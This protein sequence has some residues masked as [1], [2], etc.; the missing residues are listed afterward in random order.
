MDAPAAIVR[1]SVHPFVRS[2]VII[3]VTTM[4]AVDPDSPA[5]ET[6]PCSFLGA[7]KIPL[8]EEAYHLDHTHAHW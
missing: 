4:E 1:P 8:L 5:P 6:A 7:L 2:S 3:R